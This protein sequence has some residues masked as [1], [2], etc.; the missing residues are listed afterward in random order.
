M[1]GVARGVRA[2]NGPTLSVGQLEQHLRCRRTTAGQG[3]LCFAR[4][5]E[6]FFSRSGAS[7]PPARTGPW[8][9]APIRSLSP[10]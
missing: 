4:S 3:S 9:P 7:R 10:L 2:P 8:A 6:R 5:P 1:A